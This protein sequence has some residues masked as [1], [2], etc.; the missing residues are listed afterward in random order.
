VCHIKRISEDTTLVLE[1]TSGGSFVT[2]PIISFPLCSSHWDVQS[3]V[4]IHNL[5]L[6]KFPFGDLLLDWPGFK[7]TNKLTKQ[8]LTVKTSLKVGL[9][10]HLKVKRIIN[11]PY[12]AYILIVHQGFAIPLHGNEGKSTLKAFN[13][14]M[15]H[16]NLY[17]SLEPY[18]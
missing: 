18:L 3:S 9:L 5:R 10:N 11:Q 16:N 8:S 7:V 14:N 1:L 2:L 17:P 15:F 6:E 13:H 4:T 12:C